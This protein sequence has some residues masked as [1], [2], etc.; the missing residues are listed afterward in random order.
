TR[1]PG[2]SGEM[3]FIGGGSV[4]LTGS[5]NW[6]G[7]TVVETGT[8]I[9]VPS[10]AV[11]DSLLASGLSVAVTDA[12]LDGGEDAV[13]VAYDSFGA[14]FSPDDLGKVFLAGGSP[15]QAELAIDRRELLLCA[16]VVRSATMNAN[17][18][19]S[20]L[21]GSAAASLSTRDVLTV[22]AQQSKTLTIDSAIDVMAVKFNVASGKTL[23]LSGAANLKAAHIRVFGGGFLRI[24]GA[25]GALGD[26]SVEAGSCVE[27]PDAAAKDALLGAGLSVL[28]PAKLLNLSGDVPVLKITGNGQLAAEDAAKVAFPDFVPS[29]A[30]ISS[31]SKAINIGLVKYT[32]NAGGGMKVVSGLPW[33]PQL[34]EALSAWDM[35]VVNVG[36]DTTLN[37]NI[38]VSAF[39]SKFVVASGSTLTLSG[40]SISSPYLQVDGGR[41]QVSSGP[42]FGA[43]LGNGTFAAAPGVTNCGFRD[44][45]GFAGTLDAGDGNSVWR[46]KLEGGA[47]LNAAGHV[48]SA[49]SGATVTVASSSH[50]LA[51]GEG[52][53]VKGTLNVRYGATLFARESGNSPGAKLLV[54]PGA[55]L[56]FRFTESGV[57]PTV[58]QTSGQSVIQ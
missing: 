30:R 47:Q 18:S 55:N 2:E 22:K 23:T 40:D 27:V 41:T 4:H 36:A 17:A 24:D 50:P 8:R 15:A 29:P 53:T 46:V 49:L 42:K 56:R 44:L 43:L 39:A 54:E 51:S 3:R 5:V 45:S 57:A 11:K 6:T 33:S 7:G 12:W 38:P 13:L 31:N 19:V 10:G 25:F 58:Q 9:S 16:P 14:R 32:A 48:V 35:L 34:P 28:S 26:I 1:V 52:M 37:V 21:F 20:S